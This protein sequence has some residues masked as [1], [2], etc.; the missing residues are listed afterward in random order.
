MPEVDGFD[1][2]EQVGMN[3]VPAIVFI[4]AHDRYALRAFDVSALDYLVKPFDDR[5]F[6][7]ALLRAKEQARSKRSGRTAR[8]MVR[9]RE[10]VIFVKETEIDWVEAADYYVSLHVGGRAHLLRK[11]MASMVTELDPAHF[12]RVHRSAIVNVNRV[13]EIHQSLRGESVLVL[14]DGARVRVSRAR[15]VE[16]ERRMLART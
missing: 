2:L 6:F 7:S 11:S 1:V 8:F 13:K 4:T 5:R 10:K 15:R 3:A 9:V 16:L 14:H 12:V